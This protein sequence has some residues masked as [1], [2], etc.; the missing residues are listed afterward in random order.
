MSGRVDLAT[1]DEDDFPEGAIPCKFD[2]EEEDD[3]WMDHSA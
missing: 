1:C 3:S 2:F